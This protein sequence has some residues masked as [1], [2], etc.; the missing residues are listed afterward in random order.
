MRLRY[1][2]HA[3][4]LI[5]VKDFLDRHKAI[6]RQAHTHTEI[7]KTCEDARTDYCIISHRWVENQEV[8]HKQMKNLAKLDNAHGILDLRG[9]QKI[10]KACKV[11]ERD[12]FE[13]LWIDTCCID[14]RSSSELT[15]AINS[16]FRWYKNS[17]RCY[18]YLHDTTDFPTAPDT[19]TFAESHGWPQWFSRGWT[20]QELI[21]PDDLRFYNKDWTEI[22]NK[23]SKATELEQITRVPASVLKDGL[24]SYSPSFAEVMSWAAERT[25][26]VVEDEA[27]SLLGLLGVN[28]P[29]LYGEGKKAFQRLQLEFM[30]VSTDQ[31]VFAWAVTKPEV[32]ESAEHGN[33][34]EKMKWTSGVL[35]DGPV[36]FR[37]CDDIIRM[38]P[39][40]F[41][42]LLSSLW[43]THVGALAADEKCEA[44]PPLTVTNLGIQIV[45]PLRPYYGCPS[46]FQVALACRRR[47]QLAPLTIDLAA[48]RQ[49]YYR[50]SGLD[51]LQ[52]QPFPLKQR[53]HLA[54]RDEIPRDDITFKLVGTEALHGFHRHSPVFP[55]G[56]ESGDGLLHL[57]STK[58]LAIVVYA[59]ASNALFAVA[60]GYC[61]GQD[62]VHVIC[63]EPPDP[64]PHYARQIYKRTWNRGAE[65]A[66]LMPDARPSKF[67]QP[68]FVKYGQLC[69]T[70]WAV[71][72]AYG[73]WEQ[74]S[75][76]IVTVDVVEFPGGHCKALTWEHMYG[77][78]RSMDADVPCLMRETSW[79]GGRLDGHQIKDTHE[80]YF[81]APTGQEIR[82]G[83]YGVVS[84]HKVGNFEVL[85][86]IFDE[87]KAPKLT[88]VTPLRGEVTSRFTPYGTPLT[89]PSQDAGLGLE[90]HEPK[91]L[92]LMDTQ[93]VL[94]ELKR[95]STR[96]GHYSL[97]TSVVKCST[98]SLTDDFKARITKQMRRYP[99]IWQGYVRDATT[100]PQVVTPL[101]RIATPWVWYQGEPDRKVRSQYQMIW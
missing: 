5:K 98:C 67:S 54:Y 33:A 96:M 75:N 38:E 12:H 28:M 39:Q 82:V 97:V 91:I 95:W 73:G 52:P 92:S 83:A 86:N 90:L 44:L 55:P 59:N 41:Y 80:I 26:A 31:S 99:R 72:I 94:D 11:A 15:E 50:Y 63:D 101:Y 77:T 89:S 58:P 3:M 22:G 57:S 13:Y 14:K 7:F 9:Y 78:K 70:V 62:W 18:T 47:G 24:S 81:L 51:G 48:S 61:F 69:G 4:R 8:D 29:M 43:Q 85:G 68:Y 79:P 21:A 87:M 1:S 71:R 16:M 34:D 100:R 27:Y 20:L 17:K 88:D 35:A 74:S 56:I 37:G 45:L 53:L 2:Q 42:K 25:T 84:N 64:S 36:S 10:L 19:V 6:R 32:A 40:E 23:R 93:R 66:R 76:H 60:C 49:V 30:Q 46:V 65:Y